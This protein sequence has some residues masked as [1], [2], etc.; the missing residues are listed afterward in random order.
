[1]IVANR[2]KL[3]GIIRTPFVFLSPAAQEF[4]GNIHSSIRLGLPPREHWALVG[5]EI[6]LLTRGRFGT[7]YSLRS[8][9]TKHA[10]TRFNF[11]GNP[12]Q[13]VRE[14]P[15]VRQPEDDAGRAC[16]SCGSKRC[17]DHKR[18]CRR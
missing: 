13:M 18:P 5:S 11:V 12:I 4:S 8:H 7:K 14:R 10:V 9:G 3:S 6:E 16:R 15:S 17:T 2:A 1:M